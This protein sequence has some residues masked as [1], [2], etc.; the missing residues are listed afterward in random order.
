MHVTQSRAHVNWYGDEA[1]VEFSWCKVSRH[2]KFSQECLE[3]QSL[4]F[5][6]IA[7]AT[8]ESFKGSEL[9]P[10]TYQ[11]KHFQ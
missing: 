11:Y 9:L 7:K 3:N 5:V 10:S 2:Y 6:C 4:T 1:S 8:D